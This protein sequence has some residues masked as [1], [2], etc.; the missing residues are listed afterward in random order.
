MVVFKPPDRMRSPREN[1]GGKK[2]RDGLGCPEAL[3][4]SKFS[5]RRKSQQK[6]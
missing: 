5:K 3:G 1:T 4:Y 6:R 2:E